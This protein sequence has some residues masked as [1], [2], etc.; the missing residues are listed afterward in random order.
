MR[1]MVRDDLAYYLKHQ[2][3]KNEKNTCCYVNCLA[4]RPRLVASA[5][6]NCSGADVALASEEGSLR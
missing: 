2:L 3:D 1:M 6:P 4:V 5:H